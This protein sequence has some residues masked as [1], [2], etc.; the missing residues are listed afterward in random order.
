[1]TKLVKDTTTD[2]IPGDPGN[3]GHPYVPTQPAHWSTDP[4]TTCTPAGV[5]ALRSVKIYPGQ[6]LQQ[7]LGLPDGTSVVGEIVS[8]IDIDSN[9]DGITDYILVL[10]YVGGASVCTTSEQRTYHPAVGAQA[11][12]PYSPP[13]ASQ[14]VT[15]LNQG[16]NSYA[17]SIASVAVDHCFEFS[18]K[19]GSYAAFVGLAP[20]ADEGQSISSFTNGI[21]VD[22]SGV[23]VIENGVAVYTLAASYISSD[24]FRIYRL[25]DGN[26]AYEVAGGALAV[27]HSFAYGTGDTLY[28]FA[29]LYSGYDEIDSA[30]IVST[31]SIAE[32]AVY[33][34]GSG[35]L[36][37]DSDPYVLMSGVDKFLIETVPTVVMRG[38]ETF[39]VAIVS[40]VFVPVAPSIGYSNLPYM[41]IWGHGYDIDIGASAS[42]FKPIV[43]IGADYA[44]GIGYSDL[45]LLVG[46]G[47]GGFIADNAMTL[48]SIGVL[49]SDYAPQRDIVLI[50]NSAGVITSAITLDRIAALSLLSTLHQSDQLSMIGAYGYVLTSDAKVASTGVF[51]VDGRP[52]LY[53]NGVVWVVNRATKSSTQY[54]QYGFNSFFERDGSYYGVANDGIY[55]LEGDDD[56]GAPINALLDAGK[57]NLG[58]NHE[59][60]VVQVFLGVG[61]SKEMYLK[62]SVDGQ[63]YVYSMDSYGPD[64][65]DRPVQI[66]YGVRGHFWGLTLMNVDGADF[67]LAN[68]NF[69]PI[70]LA[71]RG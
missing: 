20:A 32:P 29:L 10:V 49:G 54:E 12:V 30:S 28:A 23:H 60:R 45:P 44:Y 62:V 11:A 15:S 4:V 50:L 36:A 41:T 22:S 38:T 48:L 14:V 67:N 51:S 6:T 3:P 63:D 52:D 21:L 43:G 53:D 40:D 55:L 65:A 61:S 69:E 19:H 39:T 33:M 57:S 16:W 37:I 70:P 17:R 42:S 9:H 46:G 56:A 26:V 71:R 64:V 34:T 27:S 7:A 68:I 66:G 8:S 31:A 58:Y 35:N 2:F 47:L 1:M 25:A 59:K 18:V 24:V 5:M 13:T